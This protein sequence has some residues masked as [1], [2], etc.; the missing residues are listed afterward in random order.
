MTISINKHNAGFGLIEILV[1]II[2]TLC[3]CYALLTGMNEGVIWY[4]SLHIKE[5]AVVEL[6]KYTDQY[7]MMVAY[8]EVP[9]SGVQPRGG[10]TVELYVPDDEY[11]NLSYA[12][13]EGAIYGKLFHKI[14]DKSNLTAGDQSKYFNIKTWI[15]W[16]EENF[17]SFVDKKHIAFEVDQ[18]VIIE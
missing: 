15:E 18:A 6:I 3:V 5:K 1:S 16:T 8:G 12:A 14:T 2:L 11:I 4:K 7:R 10:H 9:L 13:N 17:F